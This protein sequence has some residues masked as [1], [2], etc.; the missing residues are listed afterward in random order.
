MR[1]YVTI[2]IGLCIWVSGGDQKNKDYNPE[3][4]AI[5]STD[6]LF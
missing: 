4:E 3:E 6:N 2:R 1:N 5:G